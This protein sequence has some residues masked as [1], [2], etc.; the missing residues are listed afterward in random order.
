M[1]KKLLERIELL[2]NRYNE[3]SST[4]EEE[5]ELADF[6]S[7]SYDGSPEEWNKY[8]DLFMM[9][10]ENSTLISDKEIDAMLALRK[11]RGLWF[12]YI[13]IAAFIALLV[14]F[15][16]HNVEK[17]N[18]PE[19][20]RNA[21]SL[22]TR[23]RDSL[24]KG[25][26]VSEGANMIDSMALVAKTS[27]LSSSPV[28]LKSENQTHTKI[29]EHSKNSDISSSIKLVPQSED[30]VIGMQAKSTT[31]DSIVTPTLSINEFFLSADSVSLSVLSNMAANKA[32]VNP[33]TISGQLSNNISLRG[34][35]KYD[36]L[37]EYKNEFLRINSYH[38]QLNTSSLS[39]QL[40]SSNKIITK[41]DNSISFTVDEGLSP[42]A[43]EKSYGMRMMDGEEVAKHILSYESTKDN[44][45]IVASSFA[46]EHN[47]CYYGKDNFFKCIVAAYANHK[48]LILS[49]DMIWLLISQGFS[50]YANEHSEE[51]RPLL[52]NHDGQIE[53]T[54]VTDKELLT[55]KADW[56]TIMEDFADSIQLHTKGNI[57]KTMTADFSTT[58]STS[59]IVSEITLMASVKS[60]FEYV[61]LYISCGIP[62][63]TL[64]GTV[65][66]WQLVLDKAKELRIYGFKEWIDDIEPILEEFV[67]TANGEVNQR[68]WQ[69]MVKQKR[70]DSLRGGDC[71]PVMATE[72]DGWI[73]KFFPDE[74]GYTLDK[75]PH[76]ENMPEDRVRVAFRYIII[77]PM[78]NNTVISDIPMEL[79]AGFVGA[80]ENIENNTLT[81]KI[82]WFV[83]TNDDEDD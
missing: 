34:K 80:E 33:T 12:R 6:F 79:V 61:V 50:R 9:F 69:S 14:G 82:G 26:L 68:F 16:L 63:I 15:F 72:L 66:D 18:S 49:P 60:Y 48:S 31:K 70:V 17:D 13:G 46:D 23:E 54:V 10:A 76:D 35:D 57:A 37:S 65:T 55:E 78:S 5:R 27:E 32:T 38:D 11:N 51:M 24:Q 42:I 67:R 75:K 59:R 53:L 3:A 74:N 45:N 19:D 52:V 81:P 28:R 56:E 25:L 2:L 43:K 62:S 73:L 47:L 39:K 20:Y 36:K 40:A 29:V 64:K 44:V 22:Q 83:R 30:V 41:T 71:I 58:T 7:Q 1:D 8:R 4:D 77:D 21:I